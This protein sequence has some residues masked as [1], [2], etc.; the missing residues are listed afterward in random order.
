LHAGEDDAD[1]RIA[2]A[3]ALHDR[4]QVGAGRR[5]RQPP[6]AVVATQFEHEDIHRLSQHP[7]DAPES[8]RRRVAAQA[9]IHHPVGQSLAVDLRLQEA[10]KGVGD[11]VLQPVAGRQAV[12]EE[13]EGGP[14]VRPGFVGVGQRRKAADD[15]AEA[16]LEK[17]EKAGHGVAVWPAHGLFRGCLQWFIPC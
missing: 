1:L 16:E 2:G 3:D 14:W 5:Q 8:S 6:E 11:M 13:H 17:E 4:L 10:G 9:G 12:A 7:V 15:E